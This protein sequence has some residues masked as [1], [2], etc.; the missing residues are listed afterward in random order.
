[1]DI[2]RVIHVLRVLELYTSE[3]CERDQPQPPCVKEARALLV[4][5]RR[6]RQAEIR[7]K[8]R[9]QWV[10]RYFRWGLDKK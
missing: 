5:L 10:S 6:E 1:M 3:M 8:K 2:N 7:E 4:E 9:L